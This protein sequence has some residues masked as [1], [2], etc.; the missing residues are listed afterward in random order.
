VA[1]G[2][3]E[4]SLAEVRRLSAQGALEVE[5]RT[6]NGILVKGRLDFIDNTVDP[7]TGTIRL[8]AT[9]ANRNSELWPGEFVQV[10][11]RLRVENGKVVIPESAVQE[12]VDG[13]Y[14]WRV[15]SNV[16]TMMPV[17]VERSYQQQNSDGSITSL[18]VLGVKG[19][20]PGDAVV[21]QGQ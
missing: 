11:L 7:A 2:I 5:A 13:K 9:F 15:D 4:Q 14:T 10:R 17:T 18:A 8:K 16:A 6:G 12:G 20:R 19:P 3:P 21:T 1:F